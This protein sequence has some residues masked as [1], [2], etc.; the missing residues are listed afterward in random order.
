MSSLLEFIKARLPNPHPQNQKSGPKPLA[1]LLALPNELKLQIISYIPDKEDPE[2]T[3]IILRHTHRIFRDIIPPRPYGP[4]VPFNSTLREARKKRLL[5]AEHK[6]PQLIP[7][8]M[9]PCYR[10]LYVLD[11]L[12]FDLFEGGMPGGGR[13]K[14]LGY[15]KA[16]TRFCSRCV[17]DLADLRTGVRRI[18]EKTDRGP[19]EALTMRLN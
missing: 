16:H 14:S 18:P 8:K 3:L 2:P 1:P 17:A 10:C 11:R 6:Y 4:P 5:Q 9:L 7:R 15:R 12:E 19:F 13:L